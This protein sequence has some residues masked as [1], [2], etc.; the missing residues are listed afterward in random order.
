M[1]SK[2][3]TVLS[4]NSA[5]K[6]TKT[7][8][9]DI[10]NQVPFDNRIL[11]S[12]E[13]HKLWCRIIAEFTSTDPILAMCCNKA[14]EFKLDNEMLLVGFEHDTNMLLLD[15]EKNRKIILD[16]LYKNRR[17]LQT[18]FYLIEKPI[19]DTEEKINRIKGLFDS[20][21]LKITKK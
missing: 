10:K 15:D 11:P 3:D 12:V 4:E 20:S 8:Q 16:K 21:I 1:K 17:E 13:Y 7:V 5:D 6:A 14:K 2:K 18:K 9:K 19:D